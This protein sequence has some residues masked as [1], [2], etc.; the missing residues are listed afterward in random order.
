MPSSTRTYERPKG[1]VIGIDPGFDRC[2]VAI[3]EKENGKEKLLFSACIKTNP[4]DPPEERL[5]IIGEEI[6]KIIRKWKPR[7]LAIEKLFFNQNVSTALKVAEARGVILYEA[8]KADI[9]V[10]EYS[11]QDVKIAVTGYGKADKRQVES[12]ALRI[13][14]LKEV[15]KYDDET[16]SIAVGITH[17]A[18]H[19]GR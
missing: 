13:L 15:P 4:K 6:Q 8:G 18:S 2:G 10:Y 1:R 19:T 3:L 14:G 16:D 7:S 12:M 9:S 17:L 11:P 5:R